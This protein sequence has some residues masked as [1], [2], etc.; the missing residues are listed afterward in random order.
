[1][2]S[3]GYSVRL[4]NPD[5]EGGWQEVGIVSQDYLLVPNR[6]VRN[7]AQEIAG[8]TSLPW[9]EKKVFF[10]GKR[11]VYGLAC[12]EGITQRVSPGDIVGLGMLFENSYDGSRKLA[13]SLF[14]YRLACSNGM[15]A[16][17]YFARMR[18]KHTLS[19][20]GWESDIERAMTMLGAAE[21]GLTTF[22]Q[23][24]KALH[25][26]ELGSRELQALRSGPLQD[27]PVTLWGKAMD[28]YLTAEEHTGWGLLNAGTELVWHED[29]GRATMSDFRYNETFTQ[30][31]IRYALDHQN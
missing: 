23:G 4:E 27:L 26:M 3:K 18:F 17:D 1:M 15:L 19:S 14:A 28:Q 2:Q 31:L 6:Q 5:A 11:F 20:E 29:N 16:P 13:A 24:A 12:R 9:Q 7:M 8:R 30:G 22:A 25:Q 10:D 21:E